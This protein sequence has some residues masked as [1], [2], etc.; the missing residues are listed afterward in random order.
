M[1]RPIRSRTAKKRS[2]KSKTLP[3]GKQ[4]YLLLILGVAVIIAGYLFMLEGSVDGFMPIK[5]SPVLLIV[6]Y[7]I[8]IPYALLY[9]AKE[10]D[11]SQPV[12][13]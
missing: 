8:I 6:G 9:R 5:L 13:P 7:C 4:N 2:V 3:L 1:A 10:I 12:K 11:E